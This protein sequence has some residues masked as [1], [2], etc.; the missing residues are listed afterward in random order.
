MTSL[1]SFGVTKQLLAEAGIER[2]TTIRNARSEAI[3]DYGEQ[4]SDQVM[5][6]SETRFPNYE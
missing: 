4:L 3:K 6:L 5:T 2:L 1:L